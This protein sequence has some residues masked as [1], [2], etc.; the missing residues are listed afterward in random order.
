MADKAT[1]QRDYH[2]M[3]EHVTG[4]DGAADLFKAAG[5]VDTPLDK[6]C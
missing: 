5:D 4:D 3:V 6:V 2:D 1:E